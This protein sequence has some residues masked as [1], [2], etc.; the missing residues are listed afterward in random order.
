MFQLCLVQH[1]TLGA[2]FIGILQIY[3][4]ALAQTL[5]VLMILSGKILALVAASQIQI[6][7]LELRLLLNRNK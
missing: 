4:F 3:I 6:G 5:V 7:N 1:R 2:Q